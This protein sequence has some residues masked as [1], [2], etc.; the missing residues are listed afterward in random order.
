MIYE[1]HA[2]TVS[3]NEDPE[4]RGRIKVSCVGLTGSEEIV[5]PHWIEPSYEWGWFVVPDPGEIVDIIALVET[6]EDESAQQSFINQPDLHWKKRY[7]TDEETENEVE[8]RPIPEDFTATNYGK[9]R[10]FAT[11]AGHVLMFDDTEG[12]EEVRLSRNISGKYSYVAMDKEGSMVVANNNG[13]YVYLDAENKAV[14]VVDEHGNLIKMDDTEVSIIDKTSNI[15]TMKDKLV[16]ILGQDAVVISSKTLNVKSGTIDLLDGADAHLV[17]GEDLLNFYNT[18][19]HP[20]GMGPSGPPVV[21][22][23]PTA[24]SLQCKVK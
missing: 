12:A 19:T 2:A 22:L 1:K 16:Q 4:K 9:R 17:R 5:M 8:P 11:P 6:K 24:L 18:H 14:S 7:Y 10:G 15:I 20:T 21:L 13:S 23:P 3:S